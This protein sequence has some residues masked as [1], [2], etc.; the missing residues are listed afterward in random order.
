[1]IKIV[2]EYNLT[3]FFSYK[4]T[5]N[6]YEQEFFGGEETT[7]DKDKSELSNGENNK[8]YSAIVTGCDNWTIYK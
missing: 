8:R 5:L 4:S 3:I 1:M 2:L 7:T 6:L